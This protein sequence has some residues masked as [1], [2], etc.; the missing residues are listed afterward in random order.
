MWYVNIV[1]LELNL[2][3]FTYNG[4]FQIDVLEYIHSK[5]YVH[6]DIKASNLV[7]NKENTTPVYLLDFGL[8]CK[9][10]DDV[11]NHKKLESD[12]R[13]AHNGTLVF[14]SRDA[15]FGGLFFSISLRL[16]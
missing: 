13:K 4:L 1:K 3:S 9:F 6:A 5:G 2:R 14:T 10:Y 7:L 16:L 11:G 12:Q 8:S 15:H